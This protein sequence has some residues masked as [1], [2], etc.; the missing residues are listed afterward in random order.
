M[1]NLKKLSFLAF[2]LLSLAGQANAQSYA[3]D[4]V[5]TKNT[6]QSAGMFQV[7]FSNNDSIIWAMGLENGLFFDALTGNEIMRIPG[8]NAVFFFNH[9]KNFIRT[10]SSRN[11]LE[12]YDTRTFQVIDSLENDGTLLSGSYSLS[13]D[14]KYYY[15]T[16]PNGFRI[17]DLNAKTILKT[18]I[19]PSEPNLIGFKTEVILPTC[20]GYDFI[21][22]IVKTYEDPNYPEDPKH[23]KIYG[24]YILFDFNTLDSINV[25]FNSRGIRISKNCHY[26]ASATGDPTYGVEVYD[27]NTK[28]LLWKIPVNGPSL[29]GIEFSPDDKYLVTSSGLQNHMDIWDLGSKDKIYSYLNSSYR[30]FDIS[31]NGQY[32]ITSVGNS[33]DLLYARWNGTTIEDNPQNPIIIYPN[34]TN[35]MVTLSF[36]QLLPEITT[37]NLNDLNGIVIRNLFNNFLEPGPQNLNFNVSDLAN[38]AYFI[39]VSNSHLSLVFKLIVNR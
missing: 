1:C 17:W 13:K 11:K 2:F 3:Y 19:F 22:H 23:V 14:E 36:E 16:I 4:T 39:N 33:L 35:G 34:P 10:N 15:A 29:T 9:D 32:I 26:I 25:F 12:I 24:N 8:S 37:I 18:K 20:V 28:E 5:W 30:N 7:K 31:N 27:F 38:G 6:D 21:G